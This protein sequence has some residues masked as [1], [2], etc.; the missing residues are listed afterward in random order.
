M[1]RNVMFI[2]LRC[3]FDYLPQLMSMHDKQPVSVNKDSAQ[4]SIMAGSEMEG[5]HSFIE[6]NVMGCNC[7]L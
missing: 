6:Q 2:D 4:P 5:F 1:E 7:D 3:R